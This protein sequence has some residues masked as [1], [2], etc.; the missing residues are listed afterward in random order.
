MLDTFKKK[1]GEGEQKH[2]RAMSF[3]DMQKLYLCI[4]TICPSSVDPSHANV[5][6]KQ[7]I[8]NRG[9]H[10]LFNAMSSS[11]FVIWMRCV[12]LT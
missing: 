7:A 11:A 12:T 1:D 10:L 3:E 4:K 6:Q 8:L 5:D 2:S 9:T